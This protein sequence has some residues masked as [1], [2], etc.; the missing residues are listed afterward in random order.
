MIKMMHWKSAC[1]VFIFLSLWKLL[2]V[3]KN[4]ISNCMH[5]NTHVNKER[6]DKYKNWKKAAAKKR[7]VLS[8]FNNPIDRFSSVKQRKVF[9]SS[10]VKK[11]T[12]KE[13]F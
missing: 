5:N 10:L 4:I 13:K 9:K 6:A 12:S 1:H 3:N 8:S 2:K 7:V 11:V